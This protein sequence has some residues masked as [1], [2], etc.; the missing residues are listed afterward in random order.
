MF[1]PNSLVI[2]KF[3]GHTVAQFRRAFPGAGAHYEQALKHPSLTALE[4]LLSCDCP[5]HD[6]TH[7][8]LVADVGQAILQGRQ[9]ARGDLTPHDWLQAVVAMMFHDIGYIRTLLRKDGESDCVINP[10]GQRVTPPR[11]ATDAFMTP[12]HV[13]RGAMFIRER[14]SGDN[15]LDTDL[16]NDCIEM[17]RFPVPH[18]LRY[19]PTDT[20]PGLVRVADLIGQM[21]DP[22]YF[23]KLS[24]CSPSSLKS[25]QRSE[26]AFP[27]PAICMPVFRSFS[28]TKYIP[29]LEQVSL[30]SSAPKTANSGLPT[31]TITYM[32]TTARENPTQR[33]ARPS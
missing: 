23:Q 24:A 6:I 26:W 29:I 30:T 10:Q 19:R 33:F 21:A 15:S 1:S 28:T 13:T 9:L 7:T 27:T 32:L 2:E 18:D 5:Y 14:F 25:V 20:L 22:Q 4:S 3:V 16:I 12:Y 17:T 11:G 8:I 31:C